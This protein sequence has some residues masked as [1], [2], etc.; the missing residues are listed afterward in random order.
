VAV[1][2]VGGAVWWATQRK[3]TFTA[4]VRDFT[5]VNW[6]NGVDRSQTV[7]WLETEGVKVGD[8]LLLPCPKGNGERTVTQA[9]GGDDTRYSLVGRSSTPPS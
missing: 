6:L 1:A 5:D 7:V 4:Q 9:W 2:G 8:T 3:G